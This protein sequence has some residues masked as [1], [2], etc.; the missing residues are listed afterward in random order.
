[1]NRRKE[2]ADRDGVAV[3]N[4]RSAGAIPLL[5]S[6]TSEYCT[7]LESYNNVN[8]ITKNPFDSRRTAGGSSSGEGAL[9]GAGASLF[10]VGSDFLGSIRIPAMYCGIFGHKPTGGIVSVDGHFP[11]S[12]DEG[13]RKMLVVGP[14]SRYAKDLPTL[15]HIMAGEEKAKALKLTEPLKTKDVKVIIRILLDTN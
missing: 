1:M 4:L 9:I 14:M 12:P 10:G 8:G 7:N 6:S 15:L 13:F 11:T 3:A 2:R 5:V